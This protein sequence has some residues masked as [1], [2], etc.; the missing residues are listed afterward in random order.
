MV[1]NVAGFLAMAFPAHIGL[2]SERAHFREFQVPFPRGLEFD[3]LGHGHFSFGS[4]LGPMPPLREWI[5]LPPD[6]RTQE[7]DP[8]GAL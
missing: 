6:F 5:M 3:R 8:S 2:K 7:H 4:A 1:N